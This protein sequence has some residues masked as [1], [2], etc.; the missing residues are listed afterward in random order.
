MIGYIAPCRQ[1][2]SVTESS[3]D[4]SGRT[5][6]QPFNNIGPS[7]PVR[8]FSLSLS[9]SSVLD[10]AGYGMTLDGRD[11]LCGSFPYYVTGQTMLLKCHTVLQYFA[12]ENQCFRPVFFF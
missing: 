2:I 5:C 7:P 3:P 11:Q 10:D 8:G 1:N 12:G 6:V 9:L 4:M